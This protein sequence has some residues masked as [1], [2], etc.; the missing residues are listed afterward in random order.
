MLVA[1][2]QSV[3]SPFHE[4]LCPLNERSGEETGESADENFLEEGGLHAFFGSSGDAR[5]PAS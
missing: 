3:V 1:L 5:R 2:V 4:Y